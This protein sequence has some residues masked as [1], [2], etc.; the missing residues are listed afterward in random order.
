MKRL[1]ISRF[2]FKRFRPSPVA[3]S[4]D[5][6]LPKIITI[7]FLVDTVHTPVGTTG[8]IWIDDVRYQMQAVASQ[9]L[10]VSSK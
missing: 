7:M 5:A 10:T 1:E 4:R 9:V 8:T 6:P 2:W 3:A